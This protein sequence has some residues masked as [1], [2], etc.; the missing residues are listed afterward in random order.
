MDSSATTNLPENSN[1][2]VF[3]DIALGGESLGRIKIELFANI[4][5]RT[6]ENFRQFCTGESKNP[7]GRPQGYK[8]CKFHRVIKDFMIQGGDFLN[9]DGT[10]SCSIHGTPRFPDENFILKHDRPGLLS[11]A[12]SGPNT[13]GCQFFIT[14]TATPFLNNK[15]VVFGQVVEGM[16]VVHMIGNTRTTRDKPNQDVTI[17]QCGE[18]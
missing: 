9:G 14:T 6:A 7:Q 4:T 8:N 11:M 16:N 1:P 13:N 15:H 17:V 3:F 18:M 12:N 10:G 2:I 5:P